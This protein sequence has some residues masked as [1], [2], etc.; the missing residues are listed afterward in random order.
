M[1]KKSTFTL[2]EL[3]VVIAIIMLLVALLLPALTTAKRVAKDITCK[4]NMKQ[5]TQAFILFSADHN[6]HM[7]DAFENG[8][9][10]IRWQLNFIKE[11]VYPYLGINTTAGAYSYIDMPV[12]YACPESQVSMRR[13]HNQQWQPRKI[14]PVSYGLNDKACSNYTTPYYRKI[15]SIPTK[16]FVIF[17]KPTAYSSGANA[18]PNRGSYIRSYYNASSIKNWLLG[19]SRHLGN[20]MNM[21]YIDGRAESWYFYDVCTA[22]RSEFWDIK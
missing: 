12:V 9:G 5:I 6:G 1:H 21:G 8:N 22:T 3:L 19:S 14:E 16:R 17:D 4:S 11:G 18:P 15:F 13:T 10:Y 7:P 2:I 20:K